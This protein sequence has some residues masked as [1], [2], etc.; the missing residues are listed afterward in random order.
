VFKDSGREMVTIKIPLVL[1]VMI[2]GIV[3]FYLKAQL[4]QLFEG[5]K[6]MKTTSNG[7]LFDT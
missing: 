5:I 3:S 6:I 1:L 2:V 7:R 4:I